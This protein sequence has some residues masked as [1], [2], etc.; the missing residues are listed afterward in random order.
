VPLSNDRGLSEEI[1]IMRLAQAALAAGDAPTALSK[2]AEHESKFPQGALAEERLAAQVFALC[3]SSRT[4]EGQ[5]KAR[6]FLEQHPSSPLA[7]RVKT[8]CEK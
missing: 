3:G 4:V 7:A 5:A 6:K 2:L 8:A 1:A